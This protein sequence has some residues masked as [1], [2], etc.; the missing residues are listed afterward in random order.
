MTHDDPETAMAD[1]VGRAEAAFGLELQAGEML[2]NG[3]A[4]V[5]RASSLRGRVQGPGSSSSSRKSIASTS[6][7]KA[8][9]WACSRAFPT[10]RDAR[11]NRSS[12]WSSAWLRPIQSSIRSGFYDAMYWHCICPFSADIANRMDVAYRESR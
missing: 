11:R 8:L 4:T 10:L 6:F 9:V 7:V 12:A 5:I 3:R 1:I 2:R